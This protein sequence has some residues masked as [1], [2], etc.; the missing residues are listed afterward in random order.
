M[1]RRV[2]VRAGET[3]HVVIPCL[4]SP[5]P[6][7]EWSKEGK[8]VVTKRFYSEVANEEILFHIDDSNR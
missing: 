7:V 5:A 3:I 1:N 2:R 6:K 8:S 4:G